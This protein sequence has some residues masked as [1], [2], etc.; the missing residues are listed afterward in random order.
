MGVGRAGSTVASLMET[1]AEILLGLKSMHEGFIL[2]FLYPPR[3]FLT[4]LVGVTKL[5]F[6][7]FMRTYV[8]VNARER[9]GCFGTLS[10]IRGHTWEAGRFKGTRTRFPPVTRSTFYPNPIPPN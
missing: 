8:A 7:C 10:K 6:P 3:F 4:L 9:R 2:T 1:E 5:S